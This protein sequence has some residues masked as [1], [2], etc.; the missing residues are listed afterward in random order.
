M[1]DRI[2]SAVIILGITI[3]S[4]LFCKTLFFPILM[5]LLSFQAVFEALKCFSLKKNPALFLPLYISSLLPLAAYFFKTET[6]F[7]I[8]FCAI[9]F[10]IFII[11]ALTAIEVPRPE[12]S[13]VSCA[14]LLSLFAVAGFTSLVVLSKLTNGMYLLFF[15]FIA[16]WATDAG[17]LFIGRF[18]GKHKL[19][20][21]LSPKKTIEG[22][23]GGLFIGTLL[24]TLFV[25]I[26]DVIDPSL[27]PNY[28]VVVVTGLLTSVVSQAGDLA[29]SAIK[30]GSGIKD[31][32]N[33]LPGHGGIL[34]RFDSTYAVSLAL[35]LITSTFAM[36]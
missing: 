13:K 32:S 21:A 2:K 36:F 5:T 22:F 31:F 10:V 17:A 26:V 14:T 27:N 25:I 18:F 35:L 29:F 4:V 1:L 8:A 15:A 34:D 11:L 24:L 20:P 7:K 30:R 6:L 3:P 16:S 28:I 19:C 9:F 12:F 33:L 23:F